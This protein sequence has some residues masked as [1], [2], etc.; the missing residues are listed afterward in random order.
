MEVGGRTRRW[1]NPGRSCHGDDR[2]TGRELERTSS[3]P[4]W[5]C[6]TA[7]GVE[8]AA[9]VCAAP[10]TEQ[11][12][13]CQALLDALILIWGDT[14]GF[15]DVSCEDAGLWA[16]VALNLLQYGF[17]ASHNSRLQ[18]TRRSHTTTQHGRT[19]AGIAR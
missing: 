11:T 18:A 2:H 9:P 1:S 17:N 6:P 8:E 15:R 4:T 13:V 12:S 3:D 10:P 14:R 5:A 16:N 7:M 19:C